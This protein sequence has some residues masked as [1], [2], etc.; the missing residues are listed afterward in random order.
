MGLSS[1]GQKGYILTTFKDRRIYNFICELRGWLEVP[2][3]M[4]MYKEINQN[5]EMSPFCLQ[6]ITE[7]IEMH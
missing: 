5:F 4:S 7:N 2:G 3:S 1:F 6:F